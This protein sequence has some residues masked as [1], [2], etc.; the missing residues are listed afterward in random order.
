[1]SE[2]DLFLHKCPNCNATLEF[3]I[4]SGMV[5]CRFCGSR[6]DVNSLITEAGRSDAQGQTAPQA[7]QEQPGGNNVPDV[8]GGTQAETASDA[9]QYAEFDWGEYKKQLDRRDLTGTTVYLCNTC[10]AEVVVSS[11][12][13]AS[14]CPYCD[15][16]L[17]VTENV[18]SGLRPNGIIPFKITPKDLPRRV[19]E[20]YKGRKLLPRNF[21]S[22]NKMNS[23]QGVYVPFW[24]YDCHLDGV[25]TLKGTHSTSTRSGDYRYTTTETFN[26]ERDAEMQFRR[27]PVDG[28]I[29][30]PDD[31]MDSI[32]PFDYSEMVDFN[33]GYLTGFVAD[34][35]DSDPD[36]CLPRVSRRVENSSI[37]LLRETITNYSDVSLKSNLMKITNSSVK[38]VMLPVYL[39][40]CKYAGKQY[41]YAVNGQTGKV[42]GELPRSKWQ[43]WK[44]FLSAFLL[45]GAIAFAIIY[46]LMGG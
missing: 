46:K 28:S 24:L 35:F 34:R 38:Y 19:R 31:L 13:A 21:F 37:E 36:D 1:M 45:V 42:V 10:G 8:L 15:N 17:I 11:T 18:S 44:A 27:I 22:D 16:N 26:L 30:M 14:K 2:K 20:F 40:T 3:D 32:E 25:M 12:T 41:Q 5:E 9:H 23:V 7:S 4:E 43:S 39:F 33:S 6:F 29:R